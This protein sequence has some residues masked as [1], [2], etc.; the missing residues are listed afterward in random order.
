MCG[1]GKAPRV[2]LYH[3]RE[4]MPAERA[5]HEGQSFGPSAALRLGVQVVLVVWRD[6][7]TSRRLPSN[8]LY[9]ERWDQEL[10]RDEGPSGQRIVGVSACSD[11]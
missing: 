10:L 8:R 3:P 2:S 1:G 4:E 11:G 5:T 7:Q 9:A 6:A